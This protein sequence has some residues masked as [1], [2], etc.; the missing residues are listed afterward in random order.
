MAFDA[1]GR[2]LVAGS[3]S[4]PT[5]ADVHPAPLRCQWHAGHDDFGIQGVVAPV[6]A[7]ADEAREIR[8][9]ADGRILIVGSASNG[10][11]ADF[12]VQRFWP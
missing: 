4:G 9:A 6:A 12:L 3:T 7:G 5:D 10:T 8:F 1:A 11:D 2:L